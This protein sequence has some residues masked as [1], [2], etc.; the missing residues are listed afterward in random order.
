MRRERE[1]GGAKGE[2]EDA[3]RRETSPMRAERWK[4]VGEMWAAGVRRRTRIGRRSCEI[5]E[6]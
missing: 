2:G 4:R 6:R 5:G 3:A 1:I